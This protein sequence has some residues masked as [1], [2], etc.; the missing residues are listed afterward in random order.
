MFFSLVMSSKKMA[1][2]KAMM[3]KSKY[4]HF[5][6][7]MEETLSLI[8]IPLDEVSFLINKQGCNIPIEF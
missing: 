2:K 1:I 3:F 4:V 6:F 7:K 5:D 8:L